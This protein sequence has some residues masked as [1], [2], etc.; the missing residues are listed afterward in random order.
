MKQ[1]IFSGWTFG[2]ALYS[3]LGGIIIVQSIMEHEWMGLLLGGYFAAMGV[4]AFGCA[5]GNCFGAGIVPQTKVGTKAD[6]R[7]IEFEEIKTK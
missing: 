6:I 2:R 5:A 3:V 4:F 1:R 7:D